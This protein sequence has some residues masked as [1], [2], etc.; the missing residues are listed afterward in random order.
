MITEAEIQVIARAAQSSM[1]SLRAVATMLNI[2]LQDWDLLAE[3]ERREKILL[4]LET[5]VKKADAYD[6]MMIH[7][8]TLLPKI[9]PIMQEKI[10]YETQVYDNVVEL[11]QSLPV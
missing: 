4:K 8:K 10:N 2:D 11:I 7:L 3:A 1:V 9:C 5:L 6:T